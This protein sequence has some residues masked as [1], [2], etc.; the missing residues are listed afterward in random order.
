[1]DWVLELDTL[2]LVGHHV[3]LSKASFRVSEVLKV[4]QF[5]SLIACAFEQGKL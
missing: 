1:M 5:K 2:G 3:H 4:K